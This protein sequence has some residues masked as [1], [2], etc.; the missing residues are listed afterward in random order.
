MVEREKMS[1]KEQKGAFGKVEALEEAIGIT[2]EDPVPLQTRIQHIAQGI[3][4]STEQFLE[5][6]PDIPTQIQI[7]HSIVFPTIEEN[8][9]DEINELR[10]EISQIRSNINHMPVS[11][12]GCFG[13]SPDYYQ[14]R[15]C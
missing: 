8:D 3:F 14:S 1:S 2:Y 9:K 6:N 4:E 10:E 5:D 15:S 13:T 7:L 12:G 11:S